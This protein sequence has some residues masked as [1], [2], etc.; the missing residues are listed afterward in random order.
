MYNWP[1]LNGAS[2]DVSVN[3]QSTGRDNVLFRVPLL[4]VANWGGGGLD[5]WAFG[6]QDCRR[7]R[8]RIKQPLSLAVS[9]IKVEL[10]VSLSPIPRHDDDDDGHP[11]GSIEYSR[12]VSVTLS[13]W[14]CVCAITKDD[15]VRLSLSL[16]LFPL[17]LDPERKRQKVEAT[18]PSA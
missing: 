13:I 7:H 16:S 12:L 9:C 3:A 17:H 2:I 10:P 18:G 1:V 5:E 14:P 4:F 6:P 11:S 15:R 8:R